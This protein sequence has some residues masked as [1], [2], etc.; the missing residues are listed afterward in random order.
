[1]IDKIQCMYY[2]SFNF[3]IKTELNF[4]KKIYKKIQDREPFHKKAGLTYK[5]RIYIPVVKEEGK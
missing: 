3:L 4:L 2:K 1:M 5:K